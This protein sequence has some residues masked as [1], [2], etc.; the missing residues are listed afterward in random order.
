MDKDSLVVV[1]T[2]EYIKLSCKES[3]SEVPSSSVVWKKDGVEMTVSVRTI[4]A[5]A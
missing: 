2:K 1:D 4:Y 3:N 5:H